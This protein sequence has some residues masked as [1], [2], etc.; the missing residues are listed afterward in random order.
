M[1]TTLRRLATTSG[2]GLVGAAALLAHATSACAPVVPRIYAQDATV[3]VESDPGVPLAD[4]P[5]M[6]DGKTLVKT[7]GNGRA[8]VRMSGKDGDVFHFAV[9]CP[10]GFVAASSVDFD[11]L[12][13]RGENQAHV[14]EFATRC[15]R[16]LRRAVVAVRAN[17]GP[18]LPVVYLGREVARTDAS[19]AATVMLDVKPGSDVELLLDTRAAKK[20]HPQNPVLAFKSQDH[21]DFVLLD[22]TF[23]VDKPPVARRAAAPKGPQIAQPLG[24]A[25]E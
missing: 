4:V 13:R 12:V 2:L 9:V 21:D 10:E 3:R 15:A 20:V 1:Q 25:A 22:Q 17:H 6:Y 11:V 8:T 18:N 16:A 19:G 14:P 24:G 5:L 23:I 7:A